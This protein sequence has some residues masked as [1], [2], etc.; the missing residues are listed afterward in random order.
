MLRKIIP[1]YT[2][3]AKC[4]EQAFCDTADTAV[5]R[6]FTFRNNNYLGLRATIAPSRP[7]MMIR[8]S[9]LLLT[10]RSIVGT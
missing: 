10:N 7:A 2:V 4:L 6:P 3:Y 1:T 9:T 5:A 8:E